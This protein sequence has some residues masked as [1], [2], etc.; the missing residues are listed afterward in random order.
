MLVRVF[1]VLALLSLV[2]GVSLALIRVL[3]PR[4]ASER[5]ARDY[6]SLLLPLG[7]LV[8]TVATIGSLYLSEVLGMVP[9]RLCWFQRIAMYPLAPILGLAAVR[10]DLDVIRP[11][12]LVL[13]VSGLLISAYHYAIQWF[14]SAEVGACAA[15]APCTAMLV[16]LFEFVSIPFMAGSGFLLIAGLLSLPPTTEAAASL[17]DLE[18]VNA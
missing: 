7:A 3:A 2:L 4:E 6:G 10:R 9:C 1:A 16:Q 18:E 8:A 14:P 15:D 11:Y 5:L 17:P 12:G 13:A